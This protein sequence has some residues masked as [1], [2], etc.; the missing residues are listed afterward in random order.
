MCRRNS[1]VSLI[2]QSPPFK[3]VTN[4]FKIMGNIYVNENCMR[5]REVSLTGTLKMFLI[6]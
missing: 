1:A 4:E 2:P 5:P 6:K 3:P